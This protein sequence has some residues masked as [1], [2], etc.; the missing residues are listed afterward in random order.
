MIHCLISMVAP[1]GQNLYANCVL[2]PDVM[3]GKLN[4][5]TTHHDIL[6]GI[7]PSARINTGEKDGKTIR[8]RASV[9]KIVG[10]VVSCSIGIATAENP[11]S[12]WKKCPCPSQIRQAKTMA[13]T[14]YAYDSNHNPRDKA[15]TNRCLNNDLD[16][17][18]IKLLLSPF[19]LMLPESQ[20][21]Y[22]LPG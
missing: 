10:G 11:S 9:T 7:C 14:T 19:S 3:T 15:L 8:C 6:T 1:Q 13:Y 17:I 16:S 21:P 18:T 12:R 2:A 22:A 20:D 4:P 5:W